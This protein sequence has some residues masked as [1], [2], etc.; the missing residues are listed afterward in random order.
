MKAELQ[1]D[2]VCEN[3][4]YTS[5][6]QNA[7]CPDCGLPMKTFSPEKAAEGD[8]E[9]VNDDF[10]DLINTGDDMSSPLSLEQ[11]QSDEEEEEL[12]SYS[13]DSYGDD[14]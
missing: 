11:L 9:L 14:E 7:V 13:N 2:Y 12:K 1:E 10:S 8:E 3:C 6:T 5:P 4:G